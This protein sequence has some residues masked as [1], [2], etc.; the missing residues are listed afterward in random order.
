MVMDRNR[1]VALPWRD[2]TRRC[3]S[4]VEA[5]RAA[6]ASR[7]GR[8]A[9][10]EVLQ[11]AAAPKLGRVV[12]EGWLPPGKK[13]AVVWSMDD[14]HPG[15]S[16]DAYEAG[17]DLGDGVLGRI[18]W[19]LERHPQLHTTLFTTADWREIAPFVERTWLAKVPGVRDWFHLSDI[20]P[21]GTMQ[22]DRHPEFVAYL[23]DMPRTHVGLHGLHHVHRG[24]K[25]LVEFQEQSAAECRAI[26]KRALDIFDSAGIEPSPGMCPPAWNAPASLVDAMADLSLTYLASGRDVIHDVSRDATNQMSGLKGTSMIFPQRIAGGRMVHLCSNFA[27][28]NPIDRA[29]EILDLGGLLEIKSHA[30]KQAFGYVAI[31]GFDA[32]Y[33]NYLDVVLSQIEDRYGD[34]IWWTSMEEVADRVL[35]LKDEPVRAAAPT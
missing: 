28:N 19:L 33:R 21:R 8:E 32:H 29:F 24:P 4:I 12:S 22:L 7:P 5:R 10:Q 2:A 16:T 15:R 1:D 14:L 27:P 31:D 18:R 6:G 17:G 9:R 11:R 26:L 35:S 23:K 13:A 3:R 30:I 34:A 20:L 25:L